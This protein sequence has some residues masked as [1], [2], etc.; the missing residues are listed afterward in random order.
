MTMSVKVINKKLSQSRNDL[1]PETYV[2]Q[3]PED[4]N[5]E[6][7]FLPEELRSQP[8]PSGSPAS[9]YFLIRAE[10]VRHTDIEEDNDEEDS[11]EEEEQER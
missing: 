2:H 5:Q 1:N 6:R 3:D 10:R 8:P 4:P 7:S 9:H 11:V